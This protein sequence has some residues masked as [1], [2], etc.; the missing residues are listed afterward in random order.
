[1]T[2]TQSRKVQAELRRL[3]RKGSAQGYLT[4]AEV[5]D[6]LPRELASTDS[7]HRVSGVLADIG[8]ALV[9]EPPD[10]AELDV[11]GEGADEEEIRAAAAAITTAPGHA[12][13]DT[14]ADPVTAYMREMGAYS[15]LTREQEVEIAMRMEAGLRERDAA[16]GA[17]PGA[18][19]EMLGDPQT[20]A[21]DSHAALAALRACHAECLRVLSARG[22]AGEAAR[23][24]RERLAEAFVEVAWPPEQLDGAAAWLESLRERAG[25]RADAAP[26]EAEAGMPL[27]EL[28]EL[29]RRMALGRAR[30][31]RAKDD[32]VQ[33]NLRLV[34]SIARK[35][36]QRG[37]PF[38]DL[39]QEGNIGL[40]RAVDKFDY[41]RGFK[42][43]TYATWWIRQAMGRAIA[44]KGRT[45]RLPVH[46]MER[47]SKIR[48]VQQRIAQ[49]TGRGALA[50]ELAERVELPV[51]KVEDLLG[52]YAQQPMS[53]DA[54][55][56][57]DEDRR[58]GHTI[59][60][61]SAE[62]PYDTTAAFALETDAREVLNTLN[63]REAKIV[64]MRFGIGLDK[65][66]TLSEIADELGVSRERIRQL[67]G[68]A[69]VKLREGDAAARLR[70]LIEN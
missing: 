12:A 62:S 59:E 45:I 17:C 66:Y 22:I 63:P 42:F 58:V 56:G 40:M 51:D 33:A 43:S 3:I 26:L 68:R 23:A 50:D 21:A 41:R 8:I 2:T 36:R 32:M 55:I 44:D 24:A 61:E 34:I 1:M 19:A 48:N 29:G 7:L 25:G 39:I 4:H 54:A 67:A 16:I 38:A 28:E 60:D 37:V 52:L 13:A 46:V 47:L 14:A 64:A 57:D 6:T 10:E 20:G 18:V 53:L 31:R 35:Y 49:E 5:Q 15:L 69:L 27:A 30:A 9:D 11:A 65:E 70:S